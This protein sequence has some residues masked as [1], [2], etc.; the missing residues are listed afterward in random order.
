MRAISMQTP[1]QLTISW[2]LL[3]GFALSPSLIPADQILPGGP[4]KDG[5]PALTYPKLET[6]TVSA[7]PACSIN[8]MC[9]FMIKRVKASGRN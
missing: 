1:L 8:L 7:Y 3:S 4:P 6:A 5:I 2:L 9:C